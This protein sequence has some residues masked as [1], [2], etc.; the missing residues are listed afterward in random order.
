MKI[1]ILSDAHDNVWNLTAATQ[2]IQHT[3][4]LIFCGDISA[5]F[6]LTI[7]AKNYA[8]PI[9]MVFGNNDGD[10][11]NLMGKANMYDHVTLYGEVMNIELAGKRFYVNH[12]PEIALEV[13]RGG[14]FDVICYGHDHEYNIVQHEDYLIINPGTIMGF[15]PRKMADC[16]STFVIYD[17]VSNRIESFKIISENDEKRVIAYGN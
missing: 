16:D 1:A 2:H 10:R 9:H 4:A 15:A 7:L 13:A 17:T 5:P 14:E 8:N 3:D 11:F 6:M 12:Y